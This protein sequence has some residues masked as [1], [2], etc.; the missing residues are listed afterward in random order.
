MRVAGDA[1]GKLRRQ[2]NRLVEGIGVQRLRAAEHRRHRLEGG[3][4]HIVVGVLLG[5][6]H[7]GGLAMGAQHLGAFRLCAEIG[8]DASPELTGGTQLGG[9]HEEIHADAEKE[10]QPAGEFVD[11]EPL[12]LRRPDIFHPVG[13]RIGQF[14]RQ[15]R[16][17]LL[18]VVAGNRNRIEFR[19]FLR[20]VFDDVGND[21][22]R[23]FGRIDIGVADHELLQNVVL[24][25]AG[26]PRPVDTLLLTGNDE[27]GQHRQHRAVHRHRHAHLAERDAVK[28][29]FH[30]LDTVDRHAGLADIADHAGWSES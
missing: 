20:C 12:A 17:G 13:Q 24:N 8:H 25:G 16:A 22:H 14:L 28:E 10:R 2:G 18:H 3:A 7:A 1:R 27:H 29:D 26:E 15:R 9:L 4:H 21:P 23:R 5:Q 30:V 19:H 11:R 6:R